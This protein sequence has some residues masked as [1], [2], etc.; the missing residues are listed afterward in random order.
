MRN[1]IVSPGAGELKYEIRE[2]VQIG[3]EFRRLGL[4]ITW[5][6]IGDPI[7]KGERLPDWIK[8]I[9][10]DAV[11]R[12]MTYAYSPTKG[13]VN[14]RDFLAERTNAR[15]GIRITGEDIVFFNG[16]GDAISKVY[17]LLRKEARVIGPS[18]A[19]STHSSGEASHAG[20]DPV[21]YTLDPANGWL[22]DLED[23]RNKVRYNPA[24]AG[25]TL[26]NPN[27]PTGVV[28]PRETIEEVVAIARKYDLFVV[29]D[30][31]YSNIIY[32]GH[33]PVLLGDVIGDVCGL[34]MKGISKEFPWPGSRCG[35]IEFYNC[36]KDKNF[37][38]YVK[39]IVNDKMLE[40]CSTTLPQSVIPQIYSDPRY[41]AYH[42]RRNQTFADRAQFAYDT[43]KDVKG[44][45][46]TKT[47]GA[48]YM[49]VAF[50]EGALTN[51][52]TLKIEND[53][54][55]AYTEKITHNV[56]LD[57]RF[58]YY[59]MGRTGICV[60]PLT[61]FESKTN[62]FRVTL[63]ENDE[64]KFAWIFNTLR[65]SIEEYLAS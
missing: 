61:G 22:P 48:F 65:A 62:G 10:R 9:V 36:D 25:I 23:I 15:G 2:I 17:G 3:Y 24:V 43:L 27:N 35:W 34:S 47:V 28:Y 55:R 60:V 49:T 46:A 33:K 6:N 53:A 11:G 30:E 12:D 26:I 7:A 63:L 20:A 42:V 59:L 40:V 1:D 52:Q 41:A 19:Y 37:A 4:D 18:P 14:T 31:I 16:L 56:K 39:S 54:V 45:F 57:K 44:I 64:K 8:E 38:T 21:T 50:R 5:E 13:L 32:N 58:A 29:C 51:K